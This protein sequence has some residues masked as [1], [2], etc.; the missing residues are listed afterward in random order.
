MHH[1]TVY[2]VLDIEPRARH[3]PTEL[4]LQP[5]TGIMVLEETEYDVPSCSVTHE[6]LD[7]HVTSVAQLQLY[8]LIKLPGTARNGQRFS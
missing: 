8:R 7:M 3:L 6:W 2:V 1:H 4:Y 5:V